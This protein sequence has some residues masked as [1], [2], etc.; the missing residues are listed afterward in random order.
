MQGAVT[1]NCVS[2][3]GNSAQ[4]S[5]GALRQMYTCPQH[6]TAPSCR[7]CPNT[8]PFSAKHHSHSSL[9]HR[10]LT[11]SDVNLRNA[12]ATAVSTWPRMLPYCHNYVRQRCISR[13]SPRAARARCTTSAW[14]AGPAAV[15]VLAD[16]CSLHRHCECSRPDWP[17][18]CRKQKCGTCGEHKMS[19]STQRYRHDLVHAQSLCAQCRVSVLRLPAYCS[20]QAEDATTVA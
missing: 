18:V 4:S 17:A 13:H 19:T 3:Q 15:L 11:R 7:L 16:L 5:K 6:V 10:I 8:H 14:L 1:I 9:S 2:G 12:S 20:K